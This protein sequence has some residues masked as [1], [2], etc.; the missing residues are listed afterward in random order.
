MSLYTYTIGNPNGMGR[1]VSSIITDHSLAGLMSIIGTDDPIDLIG[2]Q[3]KMRSGMDDELSS[4][5]EV[6][7]QAHSSPNAISGLDPR[8]QIMEDA[9]KALGNTEAPDFRPSP[10]E[11]LAETTFRDLFTDDFFIEELCR[12][13]AQRYLGVKVSHSKM[14]KHGGFNIRSIEFEDRYGNT[15]YISYQYAQRVPFVRCFE[16][17]AEYAEMGEA[18][19]VM[20]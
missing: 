17:P 6:L 20:A 12:C 4:F 2:F 1:E 11:H 15:R 19:A 9:I 3:F 13:V 10:H 16:R 7:R 18:L 8:S 14:I 5:A